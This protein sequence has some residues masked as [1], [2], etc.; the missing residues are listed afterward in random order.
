MFILPKLKAAK[1]TEPHPARAGGFEEA[2]VDEGARE[3]AQR[4]LYA[5]SRNGATTQ[6]CNRLRRG[7][8]PE[9]R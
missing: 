7:D 4:A 2:G 1:S 8:V 3:I 6:S 9:Y 5:P